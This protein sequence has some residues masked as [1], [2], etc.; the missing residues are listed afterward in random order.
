MGL[1]YKGM[2]CKFSGWEDHR[3]I[4]SKDL[5]LVSGLIW[6]ETTDNIKGTNVVLQ[7]YHA[8]PEA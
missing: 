7:K 4:F 8:S 1:F 2:L 5:L 3:H 6:K